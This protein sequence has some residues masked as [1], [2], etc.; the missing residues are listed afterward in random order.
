MLVMNFSE[1]FWDRE[2][3]KILAC[4]LSYVFISMGTVS[5]PIPELYI[6]F[7]PMPP[8]TDNNQHADDHVE[9]YKSHDILKENFQKDQYGLKK[10]IEHSFE[11]M[12]DNFSQNV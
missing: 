1:L 4:L 11:K 2:L 12:L 3:R 8:T 6:F 10:R 9:A 5:L 7:I